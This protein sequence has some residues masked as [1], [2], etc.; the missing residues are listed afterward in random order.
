[1][2][3]APESE[4]PFW[5]EKNRLLSWKTIENFKPIIAAVNGWSLGGGLN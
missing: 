5:A 4:M 1:M 3:E 2:K